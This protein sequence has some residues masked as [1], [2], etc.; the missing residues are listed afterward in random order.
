MILKYRK[1]TP[2]DIE[3]IYSIVRN[4]IDAMERNNIFQ[5]DDLYRG[6]LSY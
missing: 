3:E 6:I 2:K 5:W 1:A 4:A